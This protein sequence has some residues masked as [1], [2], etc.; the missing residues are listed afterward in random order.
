MKTYR[1]QPITGVKMQRITGI[2]R[3]AIIGLLA[4]CLLMAGCKK[5]TAAT[6]PQAG[7]SPEVAVIKIVPE[8]VK[9]T[10]ELSGRTSAY[11][12]AEVRPQVGGI[13]QKRLFTE[14]SDIKAGQVLYQIDPA[15]FQAAFESARAALEKAEANLI[16]IRIKTSRL[17]DLVAVKAISVQD[18][19]DVVSALRQAEAEISIR[20]AALETA[21]IDLAY[22]QVT[23]PI[24]GRIGKSLVTIGALVTGGQGSPLAVI[25]QLDPL[26]VD[27]TQSSAEMLRLKRDLAE[28]RIAQDKTGQTS[29][30]LRLE[31]GSAYPLPGTF[32]FSDVTVDQSTGSVTLRTV[33]PNPSLVLLPGMYV[34]TIVEEGI[35][36]NAI[37]AP[38]QGVTRDPTGSA[39]VLLVS[40]EDKVE[41]RIIKVSRTIGD[42]WLVSEGLNPGDR[43]IVEGLQRV[44][45]GMAVRVVALGAESTAMSTPNKSVQSKP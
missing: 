30:N 17:K 35:I 25:Q 1:Y 41:P 42:K 19:D 34:R 31:D 7:P 10:T 3:A 6:A 32:K 33:F 21:R 26:Y 28:G 29:V 15:R 43:M 23:A 36:D 5:E 38:Q 8:R 4:G 27:V 9:L 45:P 39:S 18:Y 16:P 44:R 14:G 40:A 2:K 37:L 24:S 22:A 12:I 13:I 11:L 20:K